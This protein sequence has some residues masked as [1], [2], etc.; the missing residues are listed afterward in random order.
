MIALISAGCSNVPAF[1]GC[2]DGNNTADPLPTTE[3]EGFR[4]GFQIQ[5]R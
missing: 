2:S 5:N 4:A 3:S 1:T